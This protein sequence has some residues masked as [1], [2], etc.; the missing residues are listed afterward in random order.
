MKSIC[1]CSKKG[2]ECAQ[3][4]VGNIVLI[5][6]LGDIRGQLPHPVSS[7]VSLYFEGLNIFVR[8][9]HIVTLKI[10]QTAEIACVNCKWQ[11]GANPCYAMYVRVVDE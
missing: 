11:P 6:Q 8:V 10:Q 7:C 3:E 2:V 4:D 5:V 1:S 9:F